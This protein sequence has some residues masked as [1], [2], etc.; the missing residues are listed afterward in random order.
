MQEAKGRRSKR[1]IKEETRRDK[2]EGVWGGTEIGNGKSFEIAPIFIISSFIFLSQVQ[3]WDEHRPPTAHA[4]G[5][6]LKTNCVMG[7]YIHA[8]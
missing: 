1:E 2:R 4:F 7:Y 3:F 5:S 8:P 6:H